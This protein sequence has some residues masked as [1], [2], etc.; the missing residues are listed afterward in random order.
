MLGYRKIKILSDFK[1]ETSSHASHYDMVG[2]WLNQNTEVT[3]TA[4]A[5]DVGTLGGDIKEIL[6]N[7]LHYMEQSEKSLG[8]HIY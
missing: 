5:R 2:H 8:I 6:L 3:V 7:K 1:P 4:L